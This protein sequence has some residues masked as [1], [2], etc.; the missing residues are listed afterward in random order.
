MKEERELSYT[1]RTLKFHEIYE[2]KVLP[3]FKKDEETNRIE[4]LS[5]LNKYRA[6]VVICLI[7]VILIGIG[8]CKVVNGTIDFSGMG[9]L[10][11]FMFSGTIIFTSLSYDCFN[12]SAEKEFS[13]SLKYDYLRKILRV[14]GDIT[15]WVNCAM[16]K[17]VE[18]ER[19]GLFPRFSKRRI[20]DEFRGNYKGVDFVISENELFFIEPQQKYSL[21]NYINKPFFKGCVITFKSNKTVKNR[22]I[23]ATKKSLTKKHNCLYYTLAFGV[24][25]APHIILRF[26]SAQNTKE[27]LL[28]LVMLLTFFGF[29]FVISQKDSKEPLIKMNLED[30]KFNNMFVSYS[31]DQVEGRYLITPAFMERLLNLQTAFGTKNIKCSFYDDKFMVAIE[32]KKDLFEIGNLHTS[33]KDLTMIN[34]MYDQ[35]SS[36]YKMIDYFK[37][38]EKT[39]V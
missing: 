12:L 2:T 26:L 5:S 7:V 9:F 8:I 3:L 16:I 25:L 28:A 21:W 38:D 24:I 19:S 11:G 34:E 23:V 30:L 33:L 20:D 35:L 4:E 36:I 29:I 31:S 32:T 13:T 39:G 37:L 14:F 17:S 10:L 1:E 6:F 22:T 27:N 15:W 18:L